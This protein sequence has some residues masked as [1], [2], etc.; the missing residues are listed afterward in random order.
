V[1]AVKRGTSPHNKRIE[2]TALGRHS[3]CLRKVRAGDA[4]GFRFSAEA[5]RPCSQLIRALYGRKQE[6]RNKARKPRDRANSNMNKTKHTFKNMISKALLAIL[7]LTSFSVSSEKYLGASQIDLEGGYSSEKINFGLG[8]RV[9]GNDINRPSK[10]SSNGDLN[11]SAYYIQKRIKQVKFQIGQQLGFNFVVQET[12]NR[13][14]FGWSLAVL[15]IGMEGR[16]GESIGAYWDISPVYV[17]NF[18]LLETDSRDF[19]RIDVGILYPH[20]G[21][22]VYF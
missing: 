14:D 9:F 7:T 5:L 6:S 20:I 10:S 2:L 17:S 13:F 22:R 11:F 15:K 12:T 4:P 1:R 16:I 8:V 21:I 18:N 3:L 19:N